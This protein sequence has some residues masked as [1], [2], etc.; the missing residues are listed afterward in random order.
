MVSSYSNAK[1]FKKPQS[2]ANPWLIII[3]STRKCICLYVY[4][5]LMEVEGGGGGVSDLREG[6]TNKDII[7]DIP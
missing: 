5:Y 2:G 3:K 4:V 7:R 1:P 6:I